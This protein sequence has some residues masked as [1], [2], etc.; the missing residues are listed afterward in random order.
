M[1]FLAGAA[2]ALQISIN[3][4]GSSRGRTVVRDSTTDTTASPRAPHR[5]PVTAE[6]VRTAFADQSTRALYNTA[7]HARF[8]ND[9]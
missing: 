3:I 7:R 5:L 6:L 9:S 2:V 1:L 8:A 4:N